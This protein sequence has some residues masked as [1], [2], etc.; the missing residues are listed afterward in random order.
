MIRASRRT[1]VALAI[2]TAL[3]PASALVPVPAHA[4]GK[5]TLYLTRMDPSDVDARRFS[6]T[7]WGGGIAGVLPVPALHNLLAVTSGVEM[8]NMLSHSTSVYDPVIREDLKQTTSQTYGRFFVGGRIGPHGSG[9]V[10]PHLGANVALV[11]YGI[12]T[13]IELPNSD[14]PSSPNTKTLDSN[15]KMAFGYDVNAGLD[16]NIANRLPVEIGLRHLQS[17]NV[18][19][20]LGEGAVSV[21]PSYFQYYLGVGLSLEVFSK[22]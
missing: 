10:R 15:Y 3:L 5:V 14:D 8:A 12:S 9:F 13:S 6:R 19:Q 20:A 4:A 7:S 21:S 1:L 17:L 16:L 18:P 11:W 2:G 22:N